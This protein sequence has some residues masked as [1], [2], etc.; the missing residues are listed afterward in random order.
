MINAIIGPI[1]EALPE[2]NRLER[3]WK[4][5]QTDF[6]KRYYNDKLGLFWALL[7]P[8]LKVAVYF[9]IFEKLMQRGEDNFA[10]FLFIGLI[11]WL[12]FGELAQKGMGLIKSKKYLIENIQLNKVD[13]F[14]SQALSVFLGFAFNFSAYLMLSLIMGIRFGPD[15][16]LA[17]PLIL[18][19]TLIGIGVSMILCTVQIYLKDITHAWAIISLFGFW[20]SGVF[21]RG[22]MFLEIFP[23]LLYIQPFVGIIMNMRAV[24]MDTGVWNWELFIVDGLWAVVYLGIG[25][26]AFNKYSHRALETL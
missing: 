18:N 22:E 6:R 25:Y 17:I 11:T 5:A 8:L 16:F 14:I 26:W 9:F 24:T 15:V 19:V 20:T 3:I 12:F 13:L 21:F 23:P 7:N 10:L 4:L 2:N 1:L